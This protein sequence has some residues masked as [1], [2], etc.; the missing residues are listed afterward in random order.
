MQHPRS[1]ATSAALAAPDSFLLAICGV[2]GLAGSLAL[3]LT[4]IIGSLLVPDYDW[5][6]D[7]IS[8]LAAGR[9]EIIQDLGFY[10]FAGSLVACALGAA[11]VHSGTRR[12]SVGLIG[13]AL[14]AAL[15]VV[16]GARNEYGDNDARATWGVHLGIVSAL[17]LAFLVTALALSRGMAA[18]RPAYGTLTLAC[19]GIF[20]VS[21]AAFFLA[22]TGYDGLVER[23]VGLVAITWASAFSVMLLELRRAS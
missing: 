23:V 3:V 13:L 6:A 1:A 7:T 19:V 10:G 8:D 2:T 17:M 20:V 12:W 5:V 14:M 4:N 9:Y 16:I 18:V 21:G 15:V 11:N 22:P